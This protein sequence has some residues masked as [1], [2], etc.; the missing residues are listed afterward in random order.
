MTHKAS[1]QFQGVIWKLHIDLKTESVAIEVRDAETWNTSFAWAELSSSKML[2]Q[3][4]SLEENWWL[5][6]I[7]VYDSVMLFHTFK[8]EKRPEPSGILALDAQTQTQLW[9]LKNYQLHD[10]QENHL[11][12]QYRKGL[13]DFEY[14]LLDLHTGK[15]K[16]ES[17]LD[18]AQ[19][20]I[21]PKESSFLYPQQYREGTDYFETVSQ[22]LKQVS[23]H[24]I[25]Q[26]VDYLEFKKYIIIN[27]FFQKEENIQNNLLILDSN[28]RILLHEVLITQT[29]GISLDSFFIFKNYLFFIKNKSQL[30]IFQLQH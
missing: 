30:E 12:G 9:E 27:Y 11:V 24:K 15:I 17:S 6:L 13:Q 25:V 28:V 10:W 2:W 23:Q 19:K 21:K 20:I 22:F 3:D 8:D 29:K 1:F 14:H 4:F 7:G 16:N 26:A 5:G 18:D